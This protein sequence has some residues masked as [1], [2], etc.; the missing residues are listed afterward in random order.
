[1]LLLEV[2]AKSAELD[3]KRKAITQPLYSAMAQVNDLFRPALQYLGQCEQALKR[4]IAEFRLREQERTAALHAKASEAVAAG[5]LEAAGAALQK[6][7]TTATLQ[8][9]TTVPIWRWTVEDYQAIPR[10]WMVVDVARLDKHCAS[11]KPPERPAPVPGIRFVED[12]RV[13]GRPK[14][15]KEA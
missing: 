1:M 12:V 7:A 14:A 5:D 4:A 6:V 13:I 3:A 10:E 2:K 9:V 11:A 8:G 15:R